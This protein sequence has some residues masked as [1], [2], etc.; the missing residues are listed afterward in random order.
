LSAIVDEIAS[1]QQVEAA[2]EHDSSVFNPHQSVTPALMVMSLHSC[3]NLLHHG[4]RTIH[5][6]PSVQAVAMIGCCYNLMTERLGPPTYKIPNLR[7]KHPRILETSSSKDQ[8]GFPMSSRFLKHK[9]R[10]IIPDRI[11]ESLGHDPF[12]GADEEVGIRLNITARMLAVQAPS[13]WSQSDSSRFFTRHFYRALLQRI[14]LDYGII[15]APEKCADTIGGGSSAAESSGM[16]TPIIIGNLRKPCYS[17]FVSYV[18]GA[19]SKLVATGNQLGDVV[20]KTLAKVSDEEIRDYETRYFERKKDLCISWSL[21]SF[22]AQVIEAMIVVDRWLWLKEQDC[23]DKA[24]V[25]PVFDYNQSPRNLVV[26]GIR[27]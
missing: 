15:E 25:E 18:R 8:H 9:H 21:M 5:L 6:N 1:S 23:V 13:N 17:D 2:V 3:G 12:D 22:S 7:S 26:V 20:Q 11:G 27:K 24:W 10:V 16:T 4:L 14:F 19:A